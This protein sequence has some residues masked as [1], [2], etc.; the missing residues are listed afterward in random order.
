M[1]FQ[2]RISK[3]IS[4]SLSL[5]LLLA[6]SAQPLAQSND[7]PHEPQAGSWRTYVLTSGAEVE[8]PPPP[9]PASDQTR[10]ELAELKSLE[11]QRTPAIRATI[12]FWNAEPAFKPWTEM[13]LD[14]IRTRGVNTPRAHRGLALVH[15]AIYD[16]VVAAWHWKYTYQRV[17][18]DHLDP[19]LSPSVEPPLHPTYP[20]E[21]AVIA[22]AA[23]RMLSYLFEGDAVY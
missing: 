13:Q 23:E 21:H 6:L 5:S 18:P 19:S 1:K 8:L 10:A 2:N 4:L 16:A 11:A 20:S 12:D 17:R 22:G 9:H 3:L 7:R 15:A 14:L